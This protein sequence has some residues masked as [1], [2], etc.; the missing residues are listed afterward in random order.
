MSTRQLMERAGTGS[1]P[2]LYFSPPENLTA[3]WLDAVGRDAECG[4]GLGT[5]DLLALAAIISESGLRVSEY[6]LRD[7]DHKF[8]ED[9]IRDQ[10]LSLIK[11]EIET[12][13]SVEFLAL[14]LRSN[15]A[16]LDGI[17]IRKPGTLTEVKVT[18]R[19]TVT[20][21]DDGLVE[22]V[23]DSVVRAVGDA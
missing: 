15:Y 6:D 18:S 17:Q 5:R 16:I 14:M 1:R 22:R 7:S 13:R 12:D 3:G 8:L 2:V 10:L 21:W 4:R 19:G 11:T 23:L 20:G 9:E